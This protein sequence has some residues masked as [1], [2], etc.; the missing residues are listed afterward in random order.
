M[1]IEFTSLNNAM[2]GF[3]YSCSRP[4]NKYQGLQIF[5][6][7]CVL[8]NID[9]FMQ[10]QNCL[11]KLRLIYGFGAQGWSMAPPQLSTSPCICVAH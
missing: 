1:L 2:D 8:T 11:S 4:S 3:C 10:V 5:V 6:C 7:H 9:K